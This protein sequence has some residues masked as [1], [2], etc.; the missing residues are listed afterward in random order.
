MAEAIGAIAS[1]FGIIGAGAKLAIVLFDFASGLGSSGSEV[2]AIAVDISLFCSVLQQLERTLARA[3][4]RRYSISAIETTQKILDHCQFVFSEI[5]GIVSGLQKHNSGT[6]EISVDFKARVKWMFKKSK[7][8]VHRATLESCKITLHLM[9][10][11]LDFAQ[12]VSARRESTEQTECEDEQE[13]TVTQSLVT[14]QRSAIGAL[15]KLEEQE[16]DDTDPIGSENGLSAGVEEHAS[17]RKAAHLPNGPVS[18]GIVQR[19]RTSVW[20]G[21][22]L[23]Q[24][25]NPSESHQILT[26]RDARYSQLPL[27]L[28]KWTDQGEH[29]D[30]MHDATLSAGFSPVER[31]IGPRSESFPR[32]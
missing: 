1:I 4:D 9:L 10:T 14:A 12:K 29:W 2:R 19:D 31:H 21:E 20:L 16:L 18:G 30:Q 24:I 7:V 6:G 5:D 17:R 23:A 25:S 28:W 3:K 27:L 22:I 32:Y 8:Q 26:S 11:T 15:E 13:E